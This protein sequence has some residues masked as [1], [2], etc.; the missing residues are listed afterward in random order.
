MA[1]SALT[2]ASGL[3]PNFR[4]G[5]GQIEFT[6]DAEPK[7][8]GKK[9]QAKLIFRDDNAILRVVLLPRDDGLLVTKL[10]CLLVAFG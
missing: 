5:A 2:T 10:D 6:P 3:F 4:R 9:K 1:S 7:L 8:F